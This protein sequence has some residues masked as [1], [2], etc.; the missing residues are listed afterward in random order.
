MNTDILQQANDLFKAGDKERAGKILSDIVR[1][2]PTNADAW[3]YLAL[4]IDNKENKLNC[5]QKVLEIEPDHVK[6]Q[7]MIIFLKPAVPIQKMQSEYQPQQKVRDGYK[8]QVST[9]IESPQSQ[10]P[11]TQVGE[12]NETTKKAILELMMRQN[13]ILENIRVLILN[14]TESKGEKVYRFRSRIDEIDITI[15][16]MV[17]LSFKW[18]IASIPVGIVL[19]LLLI[20]LRSCS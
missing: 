8:K 15:G 1:L 3:Y 9:T 6:A 5:L 13:E 18:L 7:K 20:M 2:D 14:S 4:C 19:Y 16:S 12:S 10:A 17:S 11:Q